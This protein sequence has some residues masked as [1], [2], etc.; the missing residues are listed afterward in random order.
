MIKEA[1]EKL[2]QA[3]NLT[4]DQVKESVDEIMTGQASPALIASF[5]TA[6]SI[7]GETDEEI[8]GAAES[9]RSKALPLDSDGD[10]LDIVGTGGDKS[11]SFNISTTAGIIAAAAGVR[12]AKH[13]NRAASSRSGAADCLEALGVNINA[14]KETMERALRE[15]N[16]CFM[17]AQKYHSAMKYVAPV[18]RELGIRTIFNVL[19]PL[20][21]PAHATRMVL[22]VFNADYVDKIAAALNQLGGTDALVVL[23]RTD[24]TR[25]PPA[26]RPRWRS[27]ATARWSATP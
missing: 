18:R 2:M 27:C 19:G 1:I 12:I 13:G 6:L 7:K 23:A 16:I 25:S 10:I 22:G 4:Y 20:T 24:W 21:N 5:L 15:E 14:S 11:G 17:F 3:E 26:A 9:M 8:A